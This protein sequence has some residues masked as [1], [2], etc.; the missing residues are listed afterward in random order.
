M[1]YTTSIPIH[2]RL[3]VYIHI[4][5]LKPSPLN[6]I[7]TIKACTHDLKPTCESPKIKCV[8]FRRSGCSYLVFGGS[9]LGLG[10][11]LD[12]GF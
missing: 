8:G 10:F 7:E 6:P 4:I 1:H 12:L 11:F 9:G 2:V 5:R 3:Y